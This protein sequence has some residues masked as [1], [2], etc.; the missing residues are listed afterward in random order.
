MA[1]FGSGRG[2]DDR[3][4]QGQASMV[5]YLPY[6]EYAV[7]HHW[8]GTLRFTHFCSR[9]VAASSCPLAACHFAPATSTSSSSLWTFVAARFPS[10]WALARLLAS[11]CK[12]SSNGS[13]AQ[14]KYRIRSTV[15]RGHRRVPCFIVRVAFT[16]PPRGLN[17]PDVTKRTQDARMLGQDRK[18][19]TFF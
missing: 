12:S 11:S 4:S 5:R 15:C 14:S 8:L 13:M 10:S 2:P 7:L 1:T 18:R 9:I 3:V 6:N 16:T 19:T 17:P